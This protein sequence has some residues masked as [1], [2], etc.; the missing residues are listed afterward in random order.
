MSA[1]VYAALAGRFRRERVLACSILARGI[2]VALVIPVLEFH[3]VNALLFLPIAL[4]G[5]AQSAPKAL[6]DA[7]LRGWRTRRPSWSRRMRSRLFS[8]LPAYRRVPEW[9]RWRSST[10]DRPRH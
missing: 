4:E 5:F 7:L 8:R 3:P 10:S 9:P 6:N 1:P 2:A